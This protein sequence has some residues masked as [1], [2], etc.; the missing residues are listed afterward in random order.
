MKSLFSHW[1]MRLI[2]LA[3]LSA[4]SAAFAAEFDGAQLTAV[5][6]V[7]LAGI[8]LCIALMPLLTPQF[9]HHHYGKVVAAWSLAFFIPFALMFGANL[10][11][12]N[13]IHALFAEYIPFIVLLTALYTV[14]GGIFIRG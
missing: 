12:S 7:P 9:W 6:G 14:S 4:P 8:L 5:W 10:A 1:L 13:L 3:C 11:G 2:S